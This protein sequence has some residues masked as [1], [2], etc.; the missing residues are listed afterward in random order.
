MC[1]LEKVISDANDS[2]KQTKR[3]LFIGSRLG[4][5]MLLRAFTVERKDHPKINLTQLVNDSSLF[6]EE[7]PEE[8]LEVVRQ[9]IAYLDVKEENS[10]SE[11]AF[12]V[13][14]LL[15]CSGPVITSDFGVS[16]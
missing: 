7:V 14:D 15:S 10:L 16:D 6:L 8:K 2:E 12:Q 13:S 4:D 1:M 11:I 5:S 3:Y 9:N